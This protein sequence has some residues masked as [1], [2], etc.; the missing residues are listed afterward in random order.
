M[1]TI[2]KQFVVD[3]MN[4]KVAVQIDYKTFSK[5]EGILE[6]HALYQLMEEYDDNESLNLEEAKNYYQT[7]E[8]A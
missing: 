6:N 3:N 7:L 5:I 8:K 2:Q 4:R 1:Q